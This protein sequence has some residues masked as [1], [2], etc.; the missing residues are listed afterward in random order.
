MEDWHGKILDASEG[1]VSGESPRAV[2]TSAY[3]RVMA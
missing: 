2:Y 1:R 3:T